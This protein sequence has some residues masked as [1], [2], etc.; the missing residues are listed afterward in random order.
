MILEACAFATQMHAGQQR[1]YTDE[2]Y[3]LHCLEVAKLVAG[4]GGSTEM[5]AA[6]LLHDVVEDTSATIADVQQ[7]FGTDIAEGVAWLTD[8][9]VPTDGNRVIRKAIDRDHIGK[10]PANMKTV[11][12][13]DI[14]SNTRSIVENGGGF[15]KVYLSEMEALLKVLMDGDSTLWHRAKTEVDWGF[16]E[17]T[18]GDATPA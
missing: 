1:K 8:V 6:A 11:K 14:I 4:V 10:A 17:R 7:L 2:P 15:A 16:A 18:E 13:A 12:L 3:M 9:S 5:I